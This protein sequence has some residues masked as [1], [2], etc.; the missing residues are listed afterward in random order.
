M[1]CTNPCMQSHIAVRKIIL[2]S[3]L[4][5]SI[6]MTTSPTA[7]WHSTRQGG[8]AIGAVV[9]TVADLLCHVWAAGLVFSAR[10]VVL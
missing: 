7:R 10:S 3:V 4:S 9:P 2:L 6:K 5:V 8:G 1:M